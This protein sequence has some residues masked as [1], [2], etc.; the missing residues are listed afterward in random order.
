MTDKLVKAEQQQTDLTKWDGEITGVQQRPSSLDPNDLSGTEDIG[1]DEVRLPR[2]GI[3]QGLSPQMTPGDTQYIEGLTLFDMFND[4]TGEIYGKGPLTFIPILRDVRRV[5][6]TPRSQGG[7][8]VDLNVPK[9][10]ARLRWSKS[11]PEL[12]KADVPPAATEFVEFVV[13]LLRKGK[14]PEPIMLSIAQKNK[15]NRRAAEKVTSVAKLRHAPIYASVFTIDTKIPGKNDKGTFGVFTVRDMGFI[16]K[17]TP[18]GGA[19][20]SHAE[21]FYRSLEGKVVS[22]QY[23]GA[24]DVDD[25]MASNQEPATTEM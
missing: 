14:A 19:L 17:D 9:G 25:S 2:V 23:A 12:A 15:W 24:D 10:D 21:N 11:S 18:I 6:F 22:T 20:Y 1:K 8:V 16:P 5:E 7:G 4:Q 13:L 3:A